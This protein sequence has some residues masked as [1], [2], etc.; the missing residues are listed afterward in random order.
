MYIV[1]SP[2]F[3]GFDIKETSVSDFYFLFFF[4]LFSHHVS[5]LFAF[6][7]VSICLR[8]FFFF[9]SFSSCILAHTCAR[10]LIVIFAQLYMLGYDVM[11]GLF[12]VTEVMSS[13]QF[14]IKRAGYL[15]ASQLFSAKE[16][17]D[18]VLMMTNLLK[19]VCFFFFSSFL[20]LIVS[21]S[22]SP[23]LAG[24]EEQQSI[25]SRHCHQLHRQR[26]HTGPC[27]RFGCRRG[28]SVGFLALLCAQKG[29]P[30][31]P[32]A[33]FQV[34]RLFAADIPTIA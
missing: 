2:L 21:H 25:R 24:P 22:L 33:L 17:E 31:A 30:R 14:A 28:C 8:F 4:L 9:C 29:C 32:Q 34:P 16:A 12:A 26:R 15:A 18:A 5:V 23:Q 3:G 20:H 1:F 6:I 19:K 7:C 13:P 11:F 27:S 10:I